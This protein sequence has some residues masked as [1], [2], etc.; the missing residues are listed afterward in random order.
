MD[1]WAVASLKFPGEMIAQ[2]A[3]GIRIRQDNV[4]AIYGTTGRI[5]LP[6]PWV[7]NRLAPDIGEILI[8]RPE[9]PEPE[10]FTCPAAATSFALEVDVVGRAI[11]AGQR[12]VAPPAMTWDDTLGNLRALD[13]WRQSI[14]L[15]YGTE[16][17]AAQCTRG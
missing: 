5:V 8:Y 1:E 11:Q 4:A 3:T 6:N 16:K 14:G 7:C 2:V 17:P 9:Q 15:V 10:L 12:E 13:L